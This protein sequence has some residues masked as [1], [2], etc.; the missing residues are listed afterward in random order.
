MGALSVTSKSAIR[1]PFEP[2]LP[3]VAF[4]PFNDVAAFCS[5]ISDQ[6]AAVIVE[7]LQGEGGITPANEEFLQALRQKCDEHQALLIFDEIQCGLGRTG[8][9][10]AHQHFSVKPDILTFAKPIAGGLPMGG[11]LVGPKVSACLNKSDHGTTF[12]GGPLVCRVAHEVLDIINKLFTLNATTATSK[13][14]VAV[15]SSSPILKTTNKTTKSICNWC[16]SRFS[17]H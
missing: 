4:S 2:L 10:W 17:F 16:F 13:M 15:T 3:N 12:G 6:T 1:V 7:P 14:M 5:T 11:V 9:L 8:R